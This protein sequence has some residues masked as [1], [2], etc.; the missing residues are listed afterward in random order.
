MSLVFNLSEDPNN[1][2]SYCE[3]KRI[4]YTP[5]LLLAVAVFY[6]VAANSELANTKALLLGEIQ[7][8]FPK[9]LWPHFCQLINA[10]HCFMC[11]S[12]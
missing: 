8:S 6:M 7:G 10:Q 9:S 1:E 4:K 11:V 5:F 3:P 2:G 12:V